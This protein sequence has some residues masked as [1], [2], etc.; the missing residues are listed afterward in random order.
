MAHRWLNKQLKELFRDMTELK[1]E[2]EFAK[3]MRDL[4]TIKELEEMGKRW[5][6]AK[7]IQEGETIRDISQTTGLS[8]ATVCRVSH[9][10]KHG[11]GGYELMLNRIKK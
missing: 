4:C 3:F 2:K 1:N 6:A 10:I 8:T 7:L 11:E 9:W 5:Q